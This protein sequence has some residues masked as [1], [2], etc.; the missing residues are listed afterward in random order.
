RIAAQV[1]DI[2]LAAESPGEDASS[3]YWREATLGEAALVLGDAS[4]ARAHYA[5]ARALAGRRYGDISS[6]RKQARLLA[7]HVAIEGFDLEETLGLAP[8]VAFT[9]HMID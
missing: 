9:G 1:R 3:R 2:C 4:A 7:A 6:T 5:Q 8:I